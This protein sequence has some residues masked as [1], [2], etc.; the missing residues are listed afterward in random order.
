M[1][2]SRSEPSSAPH[3]LRLALDSVKLRGI[4][5]DDRA[6]VVALLAGLLMEAA[7]LAAGEHDDDQP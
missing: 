1:K 4:G 2:P 3:Q 5:I 6:A 7:G